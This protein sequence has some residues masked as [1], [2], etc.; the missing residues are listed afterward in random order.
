VKPEIVVSA[1]TKRNDAGLDDTME[2]L[3]KIVADGIGRLKAAVS[4]DKAALASR[5]QQAEQVVEDLRATMAALEARLRETED[6]IHRK[7]A[8][9]QK[10][11]ETLSAEI[12]ELQT[13]VKKKD[14]ALES[15]D[16]EINDLKAT[17]D[18]LTEQAT[19]VAL[20][21]QQA[22]AE[23]A[24]AVR[25]AEQVIEGLKANA[26]RL[27]AKLG[28]SAD[29][30]HRKDAAS[31]QREET[32]SAEI[33]E[34][35]TLVKKKD[36]ALESRDSETND[37]KATIDALAEQAT[38][39]QLGLQQ[40]KE[41]AASA[42]RDAEQVIEG[43]KAKIAALEAQ[44]AQA[45][46]IVGETDWTIERLDQDGD[47]QVIDL[48]ADLEHQ[49]NGVNET[50]PFFSPT[51]ALPREI[52]TVAAGSTQLNP[53]EENPSHFQAGDVA[54]IAKEAALETVSQDAFDRMIAEFSRLTN[55]IGSISSL[56]VR[57][58]VR[59]LGESIAEFPRARLTDLLDSLCREISD[60]KLKS[61]FRERFGKA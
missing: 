14:E 20:A 37:L 45:E 44:A 29:A 3:E 58:H 49:R 12:R 47:Q 42:A 26:A 22:K 60:D 25:D 39:L 31:Q 11:E 9:S 17:V 4:D 8:A 48:G 34:L 32:L 61:D 55:V 36:E 28:E 57:D 27:E 2:E 38:Q 19:R 43:L 56:I 54:S 1:R 35:Q 50:S 18:A 53:D 21:I 6:A 10:N 16:S 7:D 23:A 5:A 52:G 59:A 30:A 51:E 46:Q 33:R 40:G 13:L 41:E 15:R 24:S